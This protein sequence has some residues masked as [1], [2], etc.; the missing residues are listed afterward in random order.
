MLTNK[1]YVLK[2]YNLRNELITITAWGLRRGMN[3][4]RT[5]GVWRATYAVAFTFYVNENLKGLL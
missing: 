3:E 1:V 4:L 5:R 2:G